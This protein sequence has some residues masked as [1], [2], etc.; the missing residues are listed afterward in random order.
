MKYTTLELP[1]FVGK[2]LKEVQEY[3]KDKPV[4]KIPGD[5]STLPESMK[6]GKYYFF[7][8]SAFRDSVGNWYVLCL[9]WDGGRFVVGRR[10]VGGAW[11]SD[12]RAVL[13][14]TETTTEQEPKKT[15]KIIVYATGNCGNGVPR[16]VGEYE[17]IQD[18]EDIEI[19]MWGKDVIISFEEKYD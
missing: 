12:C 4:V 3:L 1:Q 13:S 15:R 9:H 16:V 2:T 6:D 10:W 8:G 11:V 7:F 5:L 19:S 14:E 18:M 17:D